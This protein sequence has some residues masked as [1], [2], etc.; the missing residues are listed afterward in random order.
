[1]AKETK[2]K[3]STIVSASTDV[4]TPLITPE[5]NR[6]SVASPVSNLSAPATMPGLEGITDTEESRKLIEMIQ[7]IYPQELLRTLEPPT[8]TR[9]TSANYLSGDLGNANEINIVFLK[10]D[11]LTEEA[12]A[13]PKPEPR[14]G[15][16]ISSSK[17]N[18]LLAA[19]HIKRKEYIA[20]LIIIEN[21]LRSGQIGFMIPDHYIEK[22]KEQKRQA[23]AAKSY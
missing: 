2:G 10:E 23:E 5:K 7:S 14:G 16:V 20:S 21:L 13:E 4:T 1:M 22:Y 17:Q 12:S 15:P 3:D 9:V 19:E 6:I 8:E 18:I 11:I